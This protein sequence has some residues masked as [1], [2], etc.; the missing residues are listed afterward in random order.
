MG[1]IQQILVGTFVYV[2][3]GSNHVCIHNRV[4]AEIHGLNN[5][6]EVGKEERPEL[7]RGRERR[8]SVLKIR[9]MDG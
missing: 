9:K 4:S 6:E 1:K 7:H 5:K 2:F 8:D 3:K